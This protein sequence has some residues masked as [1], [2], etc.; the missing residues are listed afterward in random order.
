MPY[1]SIS[2][3]MSHDKYEQLGK[4]C[5]FKLL[6]E[7]LDYVA[8]NET[9]LST[10]SI[11]TLGTIHGL[12]KDIVDDIYLDDKNIPELEDDSLESD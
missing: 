2:T 6:F 9:F 10:Q 1:S 11:L 4:N 5:Q 8:L 7:M 3:H 12:L